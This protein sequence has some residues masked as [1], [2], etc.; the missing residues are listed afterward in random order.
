MKPL[1]S[2][3]LAACLF[4][5]AACATNDQDRIIELTQ[6]SAHDV[7]HMENPQVTQIAIVGDYALATYQA[8]NGRGQAALKKS[9]F[10]WT[11][12][13]VHDTFIDA[14]GLGGF[15]VPSEIAYKLESSLQPVSSQ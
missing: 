10:G 1:A 6:V 4:M 3:F 14:A 13:G 5:L 8:T 9:T 7:L 2:I 11:V 12:L 15:G